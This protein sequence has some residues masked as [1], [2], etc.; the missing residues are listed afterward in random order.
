M[1]D[2]K[3]GLNFELYKKKES[4]I[5][6]FQ[7]IML[8]F[9]VIIGSWIYLSG[10]S[11]SSGHGKVAAYTMCEQFAGKRLKAPASADFQLYDDSL[12]RNMGES[13]FKIISYVDA[14]NSFGAKL[15]TKYACVIKYTG[16][17]EWQL[18]SLKF[19]NLN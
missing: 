1:K 18:E 3:D 11:D 5:T 9:V 14:Q 19:I 10:S 16:N 2:K 17:E 4:K 15:R 12:V 7:I 6:V 8:F 13:E